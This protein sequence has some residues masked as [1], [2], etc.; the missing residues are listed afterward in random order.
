MTSLAD[1]KSSDLTKQTA[2]FAALKAG[3]YPIC[4]R[5]L[6]KSFPQ[7]V[8]DVVMEVM[9]EIFKQV[10]ELKSDEELAKAISRIA[11]FRAINRWNE[12]MAKK[13]GEGRIESLEALRSQPGKESTGNLPEDWLGRR[14]N[15]TT[16]V[17]TDEHAPQFKEVDSHDMVNILETLQR[18]LKQEHK[19]ALQDVIEGMSY[20]EISQKR[21]WPMG[22]VCGYVNRGV[23][24]MREQRRKYPQLTK[25]AM[26]YI[27]RMLL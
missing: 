20:E 25:E 7:E 23:T 21:G 16:L 4:F 15:R 2:A 1:L 27:V 6:E 14:K 12:L 24:A 11:M 18:S 3:V 22:T 17:Y 8:D 10:D 9:Q 13:R 26:R 5:R 19:Q